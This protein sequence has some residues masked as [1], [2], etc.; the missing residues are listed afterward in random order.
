M[1]AAL[2][3]EALYLAASGQ[4][5]D[6]RAAGYS[7]NDLRAA[8]SAND[9]RAAGYSAND[10]RALDEGTPAVTAPYTQLWADIQADRRT[11]KQSTW[12][13]GDTATD[14]ISICDTAMCTAGHLVQMGGEKGWALKEKY[15]LATAAALIHYKAHPDLPPQNFGNIPQEWALAYIEHMAE[16]EAAAEVEAA[17]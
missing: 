2:N 3:R 6:L 11:H 10:L 7:A 8:Y 4:A 15:G 17:P 16:I 9:L 14:D 13:P 12:G 1:S 5:D